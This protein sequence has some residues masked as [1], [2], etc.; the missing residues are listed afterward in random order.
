MTSG[1]PLTLTATVPGSTRKSRTS[2]AVETTSTGK[3][4]ISQGHAG[5]AAAGTTGSSRIL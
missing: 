3:L 5:V 4:A 2:A 1:G